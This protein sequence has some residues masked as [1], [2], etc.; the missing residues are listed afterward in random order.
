M[1]K[2]KSVHLFTKGFGDKFPLHGFDSANIIEVKKVSSKPIMM[3]YCEENH[4]KYAGHLRMLVSYDTK[5]GSHK[6]LP[7]SL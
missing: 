6:P 2:E 3:G 4:M 7:Q 1:D 5:K